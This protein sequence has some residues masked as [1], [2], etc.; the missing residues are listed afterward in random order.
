VSRLALGL[1]ALA[2]GAV[3]IA[4]GAG[5]LI[6]RN[7]CPRLRGQVPCRIGRLAGGVSLVA[8][9]LSLVSRGGG[10]V[11]FE[12][13]SL[14][15]RAHLQPNWSSLGFHRFLTGVPMPLVWV[16]AFAGAI[17]LA[18]FA[19]QW[20][21]AGVSLVRHGKLGLGLGALALAAIWFAVISHS[22]RN[23]LP[24]S[25]LLLTG[26]G[27]LGLG[28]GWL[29]L[30][31]AG[32]RRLREPGARDG[33]TGRLR[34]LRALQGWA[35]LAA[36]AL[37]LVACQAG[38]PASA[39]QKPRFPAGSYMAQIQERGTIVIGV[40]FDI[41]RFGFLNPATNQPEGFEVELGKLIAERLGVRP[42]FVQAVSRE[43]IPLLL[44]QKADIVLSDMT[45]NPERQQ[46][47]A[48]SDI[49]YVAHQKLLVRKGSPIGNARELEAER[50]P[51][52]SVNG[53]TSARNIK[54]VAPHAPL[55]LVD[56]YSECFGLL[57]NGKVRA[58][59]TDD[60]ILTALLSRDPDHLA[61][62]GDSFSVEPYGIGVRKGHPEFVAFLDQWLQQTKQHGGWSRLYDKWVG[63]ITRTSAQPPPPHVTAVQPH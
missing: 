2:L 7:A 24:P 54:V 41:P 49:Y 30:E 60:S 32:I 28:V 22:Y 53:S 5:W 34:P 15:L 57:E 58:M 37:V 52:C 23:W 3:L 62:V 59:T 61:I 55:T 46:Q 40:K 47:I 42:E 17:G 33:G 48:F 19:V 21:A 36:L 39:G 20:A 45:V 12:V 44:T 11:A 63:P 1:G 38:V 35:A 18:A 14:A 10:L 43:R 31:T 4:V 51:V 50:A 56:T 6:G 29:I 13:G 8:F 16:A 25:A 26:L 27:A 9:G